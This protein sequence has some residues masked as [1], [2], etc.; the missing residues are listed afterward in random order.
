L[1]LTGGALTAVGVIAGLAAKSKA[2]DLQSKA[3]VA[4]PQ[5]FDST[6][7]ML[8]SDGKK[9]DDSAKA[10]IGAGVLAGVTGI[11]LFWVGRPVSVT[12]DGKTVAI[13]GRF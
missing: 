8:Q 11:V 6:Y 1:S 2:D 13:V 5:V 3:S 10:L 4:N 7:Q 12:T 9:L